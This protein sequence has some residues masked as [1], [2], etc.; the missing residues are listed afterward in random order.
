MIINSNFL[1]QFAQS[2]DEK[3][4]K[5]VKQSIQHNGLD[6]TSF[7]FEKKRDL[8]FIFSEE[9]KTQK[10]T[11]QERSGRCWIF[12]GLN[13]IRDQIAKDKNL[14]DFELSQVHIFFYDK[15]EK[16]N[17]FL[18]NV[19]KTIDEDIYSRIVMWILK[20]PIQDGGQWEMFTNVIEK[21]GIVPKYAMP[22]TY[23]SRNSAVMNNV[24]TA[25]L[26]EYAKELRYQHK[27]G[28]LTE[29]LREMKTGM[30]KEFYLLL[31]TF[32]GTPPEK[33]TFEIRDKDS[34]LITDNDLTPV[35]FYKKY[36]KVDLD[37]YVSLIN[38]PTPDKPYHTTYTVDFLGNV[39]EGKKI[40]YLNVDIEKLKEATI[41]QLKDEKPVWFGCDVRLQTERKMGL[42]DTDIFLYEDA[43]ETKIKLDKSERLLYGESFLT[44]A[45]VFTGVHLAKDKPVRWKVENSWG[46]D[47]GE[48][49]FYLMTDKWYDEYNYQVV[50]HKDYLSEEMK[51]ELEKEP[52]VLPPWDPMGSLAK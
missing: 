24:L 34:E 48:K 49:G 25:K 39:I 20:D 26:R 50:V 46:E 36:A 9:I 7:N 41:A 17:Y 31:C 28:K 29:E 8:Q 19:L 27:K 12:A 14:K 35:S 2:K 13:L 37:N 5:A 16:A 10:V 4:S 45:M 44:H 23:H 42:M 40:K 22:E 6:R 30:L 43:L 21:Y 18:E 51:K 1:E 47:R 11:S 33:F 38:A 3:I 15:L 52:T 32:L